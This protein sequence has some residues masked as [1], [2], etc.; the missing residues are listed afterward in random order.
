MAINKMGDKHNF[1]NPF[2]SS[3]NWIDLKE[4]EKLYKMWYYKFR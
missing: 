3:E 1:M 4:G 2:S